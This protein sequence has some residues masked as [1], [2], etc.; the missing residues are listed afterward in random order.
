MLKFRELVRNSLGF[1][2]GE[3]LA[4][5]RSEHVCELY[6]Q[7]K[8]K[9]KERSFNPSKPLQM[10]FFKH[11]LRSIFCY[12]IYDYYSCCI[13]TVSFMRTGVVLLVC[14]ISYSEC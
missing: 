1:A 13:L 11:G 6:Y 7:T 10:S 8:T 4:D 12:T 5:V 14:Y 9:H 2:S 3:E